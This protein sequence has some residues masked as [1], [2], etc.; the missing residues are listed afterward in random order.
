MWLVILNNN[1]NRNK[2]NTFQCV[3]WK[4]YYVF[5]LRISRANDLYF[6]FSTD[7]KQSAKIEKKVVSHTKRKNVVRQ[8]HG[9]FYTVFPFSSSVEYFL[10]KLQCLL[11][12][13]LNKNTYKKRLLYSATLRKAILY[14]DTD[15][16]L[17][18]PAQLYEIYKSTFGLKWLHKT[19]CDE[20]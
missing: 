15:S 8:Q 19:F 6:I 9:R 5:L 16:I 3:Q 18:A 2:T 14:T 11:K 13:Q 4:T 20:N 10:I 1:N 7:S 17:F 12:S